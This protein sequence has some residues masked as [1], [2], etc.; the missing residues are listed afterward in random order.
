MRASTGATAPQQAQR[1]RFFAHVWQTGSP[2]ARLRRQRLV[3]PQTE[4][5]A[6]RGQPGERGRQESQIGASL[7][8]C[9]Q[10]R[11]RPQTEQRAVG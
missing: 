2:L 3:F 10:G 4:H 11:S 7:F 5:G 6:R 9:R 1:S 8:A